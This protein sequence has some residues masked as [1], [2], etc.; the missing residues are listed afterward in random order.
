MNNWRN[1]TKSKY[2]PS[3]HHMIQAHA[4]QNRIGW[5]SFIEGFWSKSFNECQSE[6]LTHINNT[7]SSL[8][9]LSKAQRRIWKIAWHLWNHHNAILH[10]KNKSFHPSEIQNIDKELQFEWDK[11]IDT[12]PSSYPSLFPGTLQS[13]LSKTHANKLNWLITVWSVRELFNP[14]Y[15]SNNVNSN[16]EPMSRYRYLSWKQKLY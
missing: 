14:L 11:N 15:F 12:L 1:H 8:L 10:D 5:D 16:A 4:D 2:Q 3:N 13:L 7:K 6:H 9:L